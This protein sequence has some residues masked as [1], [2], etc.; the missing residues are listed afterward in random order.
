MLEAN[1]LMSNY[2]KRSEIS[3]ENTKTDKGGNSGKDSC[4]YA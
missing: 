2:W 4:K 3:L 1:N